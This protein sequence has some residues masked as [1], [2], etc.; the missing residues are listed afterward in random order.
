MKILMYAALVVVG[1]ILFISSSFG[2]KTWDGGAA[3]NNW[4]DANNWNPNG[5]PAITDA[6]TLLNN[7][8]VNVNVT[9]NAAS[10]TFPQGANNVTLNINSG[11]TLN[12]S[13]AVT[14]PRPASA[15]NTLAV[16]AGILNAGSIAFTNGGGGQ[17]HFLTISTGTVTVSG[18]I[19]QTGSTGSATITFTGAGL[20]QLG[21]TFLTAATCTF[22]SFAGSTVEYNGA[23]AQTIGDFP[24][25]NLKTS[26]GGT[27]TVVT[28]TSLTGVLTVNAG[29]VLD[30]N[31]VGLGTPTSVVLQGG[32]TTGSS[33]TGTT[34]TLTL[35]GNVSVNDATTGNDG[36]DISCL[37]ALGAT[38]IF[39]VA[40]D[41][42]TAADLTISGVISGAGFG[43]TKTGLGTMA[44]TTANTYTG[45]VTISAGI[46]SA[47]T[48]NN[49]GTSSSL[50][51]GAIAPTIT[52][53]AAG[54]LQYNGSGGHTTNR[55]I[56]LSGSGATIDASGSGSAVTFSGAVTGGGLGLVLTGTGLGAYSGIIGNGS[57]SLTKNGVG[58]WT[59]T[60][61]NTF[62][63]ATSINAG[64][65]SINTIQSFSGGSSSLGNPAGGAIT[66]DATGILKYTGSG[67]SSDRTFT[68]IGNGA[69]I[70]MS[71]S[72]TLT[73]SGN[74]T[75]ATNG[76][77][78]T[79]TGT[80]VYSGVIGSGAG[81]LTKNGVGTWTLS[82][83]NTYTGATAVNAGTLK[84]GIAT[85]G[86]NGAFGNLSAVT[87]AN[88]A[89]A[90]LDLSGFN[91]TIGSLSGGGA[92]GG[93]VTLGAATFTTGGDNSTTSYSGIISG[94]GAVTKSGTGAWTVS[95]LNTYTGATTVNAGTLKAGIA[96]TGAN[97]AF[98]NLSAVT[99]ANVAT[100]ILDLSG[101]NNTIGSLNGGGATGGNVTLGAATLTTGGDNSTT[102]YSGI[103]SGTGAVTKSGTGAWTVSGLNTYTGATTVN[104]GTL[105]AG[106]A[107]TGA[108]GAFGNLS[109]VTM[110]NVATAILDLS[111]FNNTIG[112]LSGGGATGGN[113]T[114]GAATLTTGGDN[115]AT[116]YSGIISGTGAVTK[117]GTGAWT[118]SGSNSYS[119]LTTVSAGTLKLGATGGA[120]NT[121]LG[122]TAAG[123]S[124]STGAALDL[125]GFTL[126]NTTTFE[127][128]TLNGAGLTASPAGALTNTGGAASYSGNI[129]LGSAST[130]TATASGSLTAS[131]TVGTGAFALTLD[132]AG[133]GT[134]SG[135][136]STPT[137]LIKNGTGTWSLSGLNTYSGTTTVNA[138]TL[139]AGV[140]TTGAN[141]AF[142]NLS[143]VTMAN[144]ATAILDLSGFNNTIGSLSGGG[145]T[146]GNVALGA[147]TLTTGGD[148]STTSYSGI[149]SGTGAVTK[150]GAGAWTLSGTNT[151]T[152]GANLSAGT[153][154]INNTQALGTAAGTF[155]ITGGN[156]DNTSA[157][158]I[159]TVSYPLALNG[160]FTY[161][162]SVPRTLNLGSGAV[163]M[164][165]N[166]Q[167]TVNAGSLV[168]LGVINQSTLNLTK[169]GAGSFAFGSQT[170]TLNNLTINASGG[171]F[172]GSSGTTNIFGDW[173]N[174]ASATA[175]SP[176]ISGF[177]V[178][179]F[180]ST[181]AAQSIGG[182]FGTT[183][184]D[185]T[186]TNT[187]ATGLSLGKDV[188]V[189]H[190]LSLSSASNGKI[191]LG[192]NNLI[193]PSGA[194]AIST[195]LS[196]KY[197][198][199]NGSGT[200][201]ERVVNNATNV[202]FPIG[203]STSYL[204]VSVQL[205]AG[206]TA[207]D[208]KARVASVV[209]SNFDANDN[210]T[211]TPLTNNV[212]NAV[213]S[214]K[215]NVAGGSVATVTTQWNGTDEA[216]DFTRSSCNVAHFE[217]GSWNYAANS[218]AGGGNPYT[219]TRSG[220]T[221]FSPFAVLAQFIL[222]APQTTTFCAG[223]NITVN[224]FG[225]GGSWSGANVFSI[226]LSNASGVFSGNT[227]TPTLTS[228]ASSGSITSTLPSG[229]ATGS[230]Y[231]VRVN[232]TVPAVTGIQSTT[233]TINALP[234]LS[235]PNS[236][237]GGGTV[238]FT[239]TAGG[240]G[241]WS[242]N[243]GGSIISGTGVFTPSTAGCFTAT[244][245]PFSVCPTSKDFLVYP[246]EPSIAAPT[247]TCNTA[248]SIP[249][250]AAVSGFTV[251][252]NIDGTGFTSTPTAPSSP[253][254]HTFIARYVNTSICGDTPALTASTNTACDASNTVSALIYPAT[255]PAPTATNTCGAAL[256][257]SNSPSAVGGFT[258][259]YSFDGGTNWS[260]TNASPTIPGC[261]T[262]QM[263]WLNNSICGGTA[264]NTP[265]CV[266]ASG[267]AIVYPSTPPSPILSSTSTCGSAITVTNSPA[268]APGFTLQ[269]S[270]DGG[271]SWSTT[272]SSGTT[273]GC[274][275][276]S[277]RWINISA[278]GA[279]AA[280]TP[281]CT[282]TSATGIVYPAT[283]PAPTA[284]N[285]C[286]TALSINNTPPPATGFTLEY[287]FDGGTSWTTTNASSTTPGCYDMQMRWLN[288]SICGVTAANTPNC[289]SASGNALVYP[290]TPP[291]PTA[292]N[293]CGTALTITNSPSAATGFTLEY[294][295]DGGSSWST[296]N[297][298]LTTPGCYTMQMRWLN[299][300]DCG[301]TAANTPNCVSASGNAI[302][303]PATPPAPILS[304]TS[305]CGSAITVTNS[306]SA[307]PGFTLQ[308]SF[309]GG[310][311]WG[312]T[313]SSGTTPGCYTVSMR[314]INIS[315]CGA[316]AANTPNCT[317]TSATGIVY[318]ATPPAPTAT[319][320]CETGL[321]INNTPPPATG[322]TLEYSF[323][324]GTSWTTTNASPTT[325]GCYDM[326]MRWLNDSACGGTAANT[327]SCTSASGNAIV[328]PSTPSAPTADNTCAS[329]LSIN[330][331]PSAVTGFTL[332]YSFDGGSSWSSTNTSPTTPGCYTMQMR[333]LNDS[334]C[335]GTAANTPNCASASGNAVIY[336]TA[337]GI[338][339]PDNSC[340]SMFTLPTVSA[341]TGFTVKY[342]LDGGAYASSPS[343]TTPGCHTIAAEYFL[344]SDCGSTTT[345]T[346]GPG[347]CGASN[348]ES[349]VIFPAAPTITAL[350]NTC[351]AQL[352][353]ISV[354]ADL[355]A[356]GFTAEYSVTAPDATT[357][358]YVDLTT[359]NAFLSNIPGCWTI[360]ARYKLTSDCGDTPANSVSA[361]P[362][363]QESTIHAVVFPP[364]P[365]APTVNTGCAADISVTPPSPVSGFN[366]EYSF[367]NGSTWGANTPPT[368]ENC[369]YLIRTRYVLA[370][371]CGSTLAGSASPVSGCDMSP[372]TTRVVDVT[373]P[374]L[375]NPVMG[376]S[377]LNQSGLDL[378]D[379]VFNPASL[380]ASVK[381]KYID[382]CTSNLTVTL[383]STTP[384]VDNSNCGWSY[385]YE[386]EIADDCGNSTLCTVN[387][388]GG[389]VSA[390]TLIN[391]LMD[392]A[393]LT[394]SIQNMC[395]GAYNPT[396]LIALVK[397]KYTDNCTANADLQVLIFD[398]TPG[399]GNTD[400]NWSYT[401]HFSISDNCFNGEFCDI[402]VTGG[403]TG[404]PTLSGS[405]ATAT[406]EGCTAGDA[407]AAATTIAALETLT[408]GIAA[409]NC[410]AHESLVVSHTDSPSGSCPVVV[411]RTYYVT[412]L[413]GNT[414]LGKVQIINV[415]D[416]TPPTIT[417]TLTP[418]TVE[419]C[420][421]ADAPAPATTVA[422][423]E[424][425]AG[426]VV[427]ADN[428]T[429][430]ASLSVSHTDSPLGT[431]P[432]VITRTY[433]VTDA[434]GNTSL[435]KVQV[436]NVEDT[437]APD[438]STQAS[439][440][441]SECQGS[442]PDANT[443]Y[444]AWL[445]SH[446]GAV[447]SDLCSGEVEWSDNSGTAVWSANACVR[448]ISITFTASDACGNSSNTTA[449][450]TIH[451]TTGP[452][453]STPAAASSSEC[454]GTNPD[455][456]TD[457]ISWLA[458][459]GGAVAS[460][461][462]SNA[463]NWT[464]N[465]GTAV[466]STNAC[467][468]T[469]S[470]TFT[471]S[472]TC[473]NS[474]NTTAV[475]TIH[476]TTGP[477]ISTPAAASSS[478]CQGTDPDANTDYIAWLA[479]HGGAV[480][481]DL[482]SNE[483]NWSDNT[484]TAAWSTNA[485]VRTISITFTA[486]DTCGN[487][488]NT[489]AVFTIHDTTPPDITTSAAPANSECQGANP[490]AN[491]D[492]IAWLA[493][494]GGAAASDLCSNEVSWT[495]NTGTAAWSTNACVRTI[496]ITFTAS[497][498][499]G[500]SS[501]TTAIF[502]IHDTTPPDITTS[503]APENS[504][505]QGANPD[506]NTDYIAWLA[507]HGGAAASDLCSNEVN[508]SDNRGTAV[509][510][511]N[512]CVRT[513][514]ITFTASDTCGNSSNTTAV[515]TIHDTTGPDISTPATASNS[516]CQGG[517]PDA[518]TDY[519]AWLASHGG[520]VASDACS[521][522]I[523]WS[524]NT[525]TAVWSTNAC[526]RTISI[527]FTAS[528]TCGNSSN[529]T[530]VFTIHDTTGPDISTPAA[531]LSSECQGTDPDANTDYIAWLASHGGAVASDLCSNAVN[532]SDNT[533][534]AVWSTNACVRTIS[535]T[536]TASDTCGNSSNTTA[537]FT[538]HDTTPP[539]ITTSAAPANS[540]C[541]GANPDANTDYIAWLASHGE[542]AASDLCSNAVNWSDNT[543]TAVWST[544]ACVRTISITFTAS[545]TCGNSSNTTAVFTIHD[546]TGPDI[547]TPAAA[548]SSECQGTNPDAN[549][550]YISWLASHGGAVASDLCSNAVN[551]TNNTGTAVWSTNAC[552]RTISI[553]FTASDTC[554]NSSNTTAVFT[555]HD[556]T[557]PDI[558][559]PAAA[560]SSEC[561]GTDPDANT[562]YIA[563]L[564]SHG[565]AV[566]SDLCSNEV[567][568]SD[569]TGTAAWSTNA[570]VRTISITFTASDTCGNSSNTTAVFTIHDTTPP[571]IT[572]S[573]APANSEC[574]GANPDA[575]TD[576]ISWLASH[577]G[578][579]ASDLCSNAVNWSDNT[580]TAVWSTNACVRTISVTFT[581][582][583]TC[584]NSSNTTAVFTIHDTTP[585]DITTSAAAANSECQGANP[586]ANTD[587]IAWLASH[588][589]AAASDL[590]SNAVN[591]SDNT[592]TAVW[593]TNACVRT[594]SITFTASDTC[595]NSS[596]T[597]AVFTI[598]DTTGPD[599][600]TPA[601]ASNSECQGGD[602]DANTDYIAWLASHGGAVASDAC[603]NEINWSDNTGTAVWSTNACVRTI[604]ITFTASDTCGNSSNTTAVFTI[605]DTTGPD[606]STPAAAS[607]SECQGTDPDAN[608]DYISWLASHGGATASDLCS[609]EV[610][611][612]DNTGTAVWSTN[613]CVRTISITFTASDTCGNSS[614]TTAVFTIHDTTPPDITTS[615]APANSECQ[616]A[617]PDANTD[618]ISWLASHGG[619]AASD[620]CSNAVNWSDNTGTAVWSTNA[621]VRTISVTFTASDTCG[622][623]SNTTAV[624]TIHD[625][626][627]PDIT[628]SAA[629]A[630]SECQGANPDA[631]TDYIAWL[632][633]HGE[634]A[635]SDLCS[636]AVNWSDNT[637]TAVWSTNACVRTISIT[638]TA[639]DTCGNSS[640]TTAVFTIHDTTGP[641]ISTPAAA[642][643]SECQ[644]TNPDANTDYISWLASHGGAVASDLCSNAV[645]WTNNTGTAV[646]STN[647]CVRT[648]SITFTA[649]D[650]CGNSS[651]TTAVFT[652][653]DTTGPDI[654]TPA[655][656]SS[657]E[658]QGTDPDANTDY[659]AWLASH[660][661][662]VASD[663][664]SN[665][666]NWS[667][668]TGTAAWSTN[669]CVRTISI[670][671]T[672]SDT[673]G[674]S[675]NT[676]A[677]FTIH[678][679]TPPDI[680]TSA[681][682]ANS[683]CQGANP[684]ANTDYISW[685]ASHG[686][687]A[688]S[689]LCSNA[690]NW[691]DNTGTAVWS[692]NA[693]VRTISV[694]FTAS[695]TCGNSSNTTAVFTIHDTTPPD[696]TTSAA[697][698]NSECQG[699]NPDANTDYIAW[700]A[701]HGEAAASD[702]C[703]NAVNWSD[704]TGTAVWSTNACVRTISITFTASDTCGN[705]SNTTAVFTIHDTTG[706]DI[707]TPATASNS[708]C[709]GG[710]PDANTDYIA[711]L[712]SHGGAVASDACSNEINWS[713]NTGTAVWSTNACVRTI[714]ITF[715]ASDTCGNSS[716]T[717]AVFTIHDTTGPDI[718]TPA[719]AAMSE[720]QGAN[721]DANTEYIAWL[722]SH[723]GAA[724]SDLCSN[725]VNWT[726]NTG[727]AVWSTNACVRT[728]SITFTASDTCGNA[729]NT[730][731]IFTIHDTT[732]PDITTPAA[733]ANSECQGANP[734][735]NTDY[736]AW[737][738]SHGG[739][740]ASDLCSNEVNWSDNTGTA[741][742]STNACVRTIS[743]TFTAADTCGNSSN[744]TAVFT[745][746]DTTGPDIST[747]AAAA[748]SECQGTDPNANTDY[749]AWLA[750]HG[751]AAASDL[752]SNE[753]N[754]TENTGTAVWSTNACVRT[755]SITFTA[756]DT[757]GNSSNT[758]AV[759]TIHDT[760]GPDIST[761][762]A[763]ANSEC[764][765]TDPNA[766][767]DYIAWLASH[768]GAAASDLC[769]NEVNWSDNTGTAAWSTNAC[770]R[771]IS[772]TFTA[773]DTCGNSSN[774]IAVFTIHDTTGPDITTPAAA[775]NSE[776]QGADPNANTDYILWLASHGGAAASDLCSNAVNWTDNTGT[777]V[778]STNACVR[779]ISITFTASDT[780][781]NSSNTTA[782][783]TIHDT[784]A[785]D[786]T[787]EASNQT[788]ECDGAGNTTALTNWLS[789][790]GGAVANDACS[791]VTWS[792]DFTALSD[793]CGATGT[794]T[795]HFT[796]TDGCGNAST[797]TATFTIEDI[798]PPTLTCPADVTIDCSAS[799]L[800]GVA[801]SA[802]F[803]EDFD[804]IA[805]PTDGGP[806][807]YS[808]PA[809]WL[810]VNV[811]NN[812]PA[813]NPSVSWIHEAW[814]RREDFPLNNLD[815][816][817]FATSYYDPPGTA[818][819]W[820]WTPPIPMGENGLLTWNAKSY[821]D[822][823]PEAYSVRVMV[824]PNVPTGTTGFIG[825][826][827]LQSFQ[828]FGTNAENP[829]WT[830]R[831]VDL[832]L[833]AGKTIRIAFRDFS[834]DQFSILIDDVVVTSD[835]GAGVG[836]A[837]AV[838]ACDTEPTVTYAD[839]TMSGNCASNY[840]I[841]RTWT[842][843]DACGNST[844]CMQTIVVHDITPPLMDTEA[845]DQT[846][847]CDGAGNN[848]ALTNWLS[849][850]GGAMASD[851][852]S[853]VTWSNDFTTLSDGCG[854][855]GTTTVHFTATDGCGNASTTTATFTIQ[856]TTPPAIVPG[857]T[858]M[859]V[860]CD[861]AGNT[862]ALFSW[863]SSHGGAMA[864]DACSNVTWSDDYSGLSDDCGMT[865]SA[866]VHFTAT[867]A[868][869]NASTTT[870]TF[871]IHDTMAPA[872]VPGA[873]N[874]TV[875][876]DGAG[877]ITSLTTWLSTNG[878][879]VA[880]ETCSIA[881]W[882]NDFTGLSDGCG[883][884]GSAT[885]HFTATD[886]CGN[887][888]TTTATFTIHDTMAPAIVPGATNLTVECD[889]AGNTSQLT[890]WLS[891]HGGA[892]AH[893]TCSIATWS[894]DF[895]GLSDGCGE[896]GTATVHFTATDQCGNASTTTATFTI[897]D[898][899]PPVLTSCPPN[900]TIDCPSV[901]SFGTPM[902]NNACDASPVVSIVSTITTPSETC[903]QA[904]S[905]TRTWVATD[906][907]GN[908]SNTCSQV[909]TVIDDT[910]PV[911]ENC[912]TSPAVD[913]ISNGGFETTDL[914]GWTVLA[915]NNVGSGCTQGYATYVGTFVGCP[916]AN[917]T[918]GSQN[919]TPPV[920]LWG[921]ATAFDADAPLT[922]ELRQTVSLPGTITL[923]ALGFSDQY[924]VNQLNF[925]PTCTGTKLLDVNILDA[926]GTTV[927]ANV[928]NRT[929]P[930]GANY[931]QSW[932]A[933]TLDITTALQPYAGQNVMLSF[934][935][936]VP[937]A[938]AGP[939][940]YALDNVSLLVS[941]GAVLSLG[942]NPTLPD[943]AKAI[944][945][946][947][948]VSDACGAVTESATGT[949]PTQSNC[950]Y[951]QTWTVVAQDGCG[952]SSSCQISYIWRIDVTPPVV[953]CPS[954]GLYLGVNPTD[955]DSD[956]IPDG[957]AT[958]VNWSDGCSASGGTTQD[959]TDIE[960]QLTGCDRS[961]TRQFSATDPCGNTGTC[962]VTYTWKV[963]TAPPVITCP[964]SITHDNDPGTCGAVVTYTTPT[965]L[966][967]CSGSCP[968]SLPGYVYLG[969]LSGHEY[970]V[971]TIVSTFA[972][973]KLN[974]YLLGGHLATV[975]SA[976]EESFITTATSLPAWIGL[977][978][979]AT[980]GTFQWITGEPFSYTDWAVDQP[981]NSTEGED[982]VQL[983]FSGGW[984]DDS[985]NDHLN[986]IVEFDCDGPV[987]ISG[988]PSG[989]T[990]PGGV[991]ENTFITV[992]GAGNTATCSFTVT[993]NDVEDPSFTTCPATANISCTDSQLP[994]FTGQ[995][996]ATDNCSM[997]SITY[998]DGAST[999]GVPACGGNYSFIRTWTATDVTG[1000]SASCMQIINVTDTQGPTF[1001][1002][1003]PPTA[1004]IS[1005]T[1006][1007]QLPANT[1008]LATATD[1009]CSN[1010]TMTYNDGVST[1011]G[1012]PTCAGNYS[1013]TRT[1014][1015]ATDDCGNSTT[1016]TQSISVTDT[1017]PPV[1018]NTPAGDQMAECD[1019]AGNSADITAWL[1020]AH[1021]GAAATDG[1022]SG[1023]TWT[1024]DFTGVSD[1025]CGSTGSAI[1026][1027][1028]TATDGC[1029]NASTTTATFTI[1030]DTTAP[1031]ITQEAS[1032]SGAE[1033][1034]G[1035]GNTAALTAW[1036]SSQGGASASDIC[1037]GVTWSNDFTTLSDGCGSTGSATVHFTATDACGNASTTTAT[1038]T[1039][1040]DTTAPSITVGA[1041][1042]SGAECD[1043]A[1044]NTAALTAWLSSQGGASASD[1045][1046]SGVTWTN[1047]FT[1048][1049]SDGCGST[1050]T[1051]M[1052]HFTA[1053]DG[1054]GNASTTT[1055]TFTIVDTTAPGITVAAGNQTVECDGAGNTSDLSAWLSS[1056]GGADAT[1057]ICSGVT[1058]TNDFTSLS[1059][1060]CGSTGTATVHFTATDG[1061]GNASTT[1062][1063]TFT[1064]A[1065]TTAPTFS[1066]AASNQTVQCDGAGNASDL[1067][1068]WLSGNGGA[1069]AIDACSG[1070]TWSNN[1071]TSLSD[1072]CGASGTAI[1073]TFAAT[1074]GCGNTG[1075]TTA[1076]F[1077]IIDTTVPMINS[1078][1079]GDVTK[1080]CQDDLSVAGTGNAAATDN[1081]D[1082]SPVITHT[1083]VS[1084][1085]GGD[1086]ANCS[1087][1088]N[1089]T[1090][1091]R[1092]FKATDAC[1093]NM[1094][1095]CTQVITVHDVTG[1096]VVTTGT[1097]NACYE[1098][1099]A[1100]AE[1101]AAIAATTAVDNCA[1102]SVTKTADISQTVDASCDSLITVTV[1103]DIC[1104]NTSQTTYLT[1105]IGCQT[1106]RLKVFLEGPYNTVNDNMNTTINNN[1107]LLPGQ[1108]CTLPFITDT[1109]HGQPY[1110]TPPYNYNGNT[1111]M[1112]YGDFSGDT[1113]YPPDVVDWILVSVRR[1114]SLN[1115][1116]DSTI[1117]TCAGWLHK[1118]GTVTFPDNCPGPV[1119]DITKD[1120]YIMVQ[1121]RN[1122]LGILSPSFVDIDCSGAFLSWD[1123]T[1124]QDSYK[1125]PFRVGEKFMDGIWAMLAANGD[1126]VSSIKVISS[1127]D[1128]TIW[1129]QQQSSSGYKKADH[1130]LN[1131]SVNSAD[1132]TLWKLN[1133]NKTTG[1134]IFY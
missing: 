940:W 1125:P 781:G 834:E 705:S 1025:G 718:T 903:A 775:A 548:S 1113:P 656:A 1040:V 856:D 184:Y 559:T 752:C 157:G 59:L 143:A 566:A 312:T 128:L 986:Y 1041:S 437:T 505:C 743:I 853:N 872:I 373:A 871:T 715:T 574:Q 667:D 179:S 567:N 528:D 233:L 295:F 414:S 503:A 803:Q 424:A 584:G 617:N 57:G 958:S 639:S 594:I 564:A 663:L 1076:T 367:N 1099:V 20:L 535:I 755:I 687:A 1133:Q 79:G 593:S 490:D 959:F 819:D 793:G 195:P 504:E 825:N 335:G 816:V 750:S 269:Y 684:D 186:N 635:A 1021:A 340:A 531:A 247:N 32:A 4:G 562:D 766:N 681:A 1098:S 955:T 508:W 404:L 314:W 360:N 608:T 228:T 837:T 338:T 859:T 185:L 691:S 1065:D 654:S 507:S 1036:L 46:L 162:G 682:P 296:T 221:A 455:A 379:G 439:A 168:I 720:C 483:V 209:S 1001:T 987:L 854:Q 538:I 619:A 127:A 544:N 902:A 956:L 650:T 1038:F 131:G 839:V 673:C 1011:P 808:F 506:A 597:T 1000:N 250:V 678:D 275:T 1080:N 679:T 169:A 48:L 1048:T 343:T 282:S 646:W 1067:A 475:F 86:A 434:C 451:D 193:L 1057:D 236:C 344:T 664:C 294:S 634:A 52:I 933:R 998:V 603:S 773:S 452:D 547:S 533:G 299:D 154:N 291:A 1110:N 1018:I 751:G 674:N 251:Q 77:V 563:W 700:L 197:I 355:T 117:S 431:C 198:V 1032:N 331:S 512:A 225:F 1082:A 258:L 1130:D 271:G 203:T 514:S 921:V 155:T 1129:S 323:D 666:V 978:D 722:D 123:T 901:P 1126:Q 36:A 1059:D 149:I 1108:D 104:A 911:F 769:S 174:N 1131:I 237:I 56:T 789:T 913:L 359:A 530:A 413:C 882:S 877:N 580:G 462:C 1073:V 526:V 907:C 460:D 1034:D 94:T 406:V 536:F 601:T 937:E 695:D 74:L 318:P 387:V 1028:F 1072:G 325:P 245:N 192:N 98:G 396:P 534:T 1014:W 113:V 170:I 878:G 420:T 799:T 150:I 652:I 422:E 445:V 368:A 109:A 259:Q 1121:H 287:S 283:P 988:L 642:S 620:L 419:G 1054:C 263:R 747:P 304:S 888:S 467:V 386:F 801:G 239:Q 884:T 765:G 865:G 545:D 560:S 1022:C 350:S 103:I 5:V 723:G 199:T 702:L 292:T 153:L 66:I 518:N 385:D 64:T 114:L 1128:R 908:T 479:S 649:S 358:G 402:T 836:T 883:M 378:C 785:P 194:T 473:G 182:S 848:T 1051:A 1058:W 779:T 146:G 102:S 279:T 187:N 711:W 73:L 1084:T 659:I 631:N 784:T 495:D 780:C 1079:P 354:V 476:D 337:P 139:K 640:N 134:M 38:R 196:S 290:A 734:D 260:S 219:Q 668:N 1071:F 432:I 1052:V 374:T 14:I 415:N 218:A 320:T 817:A 327:P 286:G 305:T 1106:V 351:N 492:Y 782:V 1:N 1094:S 125:A 24:Y 1061:C 675:S 330:N 685:L 539:D 841:H 464:N 112:S 515:F 1097:I 1016:C 144:V 549:T 1063:A 111:G 272:N 9:G 480:A 313:N 792:N 465:T 68:L 285:T 1042:N 240:P 891:S 1049:L 912:V 276:V 352:A 767:T 653:H 417:G 176:S 761:P 118:V 972:E 927:L 774:T 543:G 556:T 1019:G 189:N 499:C 660:G 920:G 1031:D 124:V 814:D 365:P 135:I 991:T 438:I 570:C 1109:P 771:T 644:G 612:S 501:N 577:G 262:M 861:G 23:G 83:L 255:P 42:T 463:V 890:T 776:C 336:P 234:V 527:T 609:N 1029:G 16:G 133:T 954:T 477:D 710:D 595:G 976:G 78:L 823:F 126:A 756:S 914:T 141:G 449:V 778:W 1023:V 1024:N 719:A 554:G 366:T 586:D 140:A 760:T 394:P 583:D 671:F 391:P 787:T 494:H 1092:T 116:S 244:Y 364:A 145:V 470:I 332:E 397:S 742:W 980:E 17:R 706:P 517:D 427:A 542:A 1044:G 1132:E 40:D 1117:W 71:G 889:G 692:T 369:G 855:T 383:F 158:N 895:S 709:Q 223:D 246:A 919:Y 925:C 398:T 981:D 532:W 284:T 1043:G 47:N 178:V 388:S 441:N 809:G 487:S 180:N 88:V 147:A 159:T 618:Y 148:N 876:C 1046:C 326:Q 120:T 975:T 458:S 764:Q 130:I 689:D 454:Q 472:D 208:I 1020:T 440:A 37:L 730:T 867:D 828:V 794:A 909:I 724:A 524:D 994:A 806:G 390:P 694:T 847:E 728:I 206:S 657:S 893:E 370:S 204:P 220:I 840:T 851:A 629:P 979:E 311:S 995:A 7:T 795:V 242:V 1105:R 744:T 105:K 401:Y 488:S 969:N 1116:P 444:I 377:A 436:I 122:T 31:T 1010:A 166:R 846:V 319:N 708:E 466:W 701:S 938:V 813:A 1120:Y 1069:T 690:V 33:I 426:G 820:M 213:W 645:N 741:V 1087:Y 191:T 121:P 29:S 699:A 588:G 363:C 96:T 915:D 256:T 934:R 1101:S 106:I 607:S 44:L 227:L 448:T 457:Y 628:T 231:R 523:N 624:F 1027:H 942:C 201:Q 712:A 1078:C 302:V 670:T 108:N 1127:P 551:W 740:A 739:A 516:E 393:S 906:A 381:A 489:T 860:E 202:V 1134:V 875:E 731:A 842:S 1062:T 638:F 447:A 558:S 243:G 408:G 881:T 469:I 461:L 1033:C 772:I 254:C 341:V 19:T 997:T 280:N 1030:V 581:A 175:Y 85:T 267:N 248:L 790:N 625:T 643:S 301:G 845:S 738:A 575:N 944:A 429:A 270:F 356:S 746:H 165:A 510:S 1118:D 43:V 519:I 735:A 894:D 265:N 181:S 677:V 578:A 1075:Y 93:N 1091:T 1093:N 630:N 177:G 212:V 786:I 90:I 852:C 214:L 672:A 264:A 966:E 95:G 726:D 49:S 703:S 627:P 804:G 353:N 974:A 985:G 1104:G 207:D 737:L 947:G 924:F 309:D 446:G 683:E 931:C 1103:T 826:M 328:Y 69:T 183:F 880:H 641:D 395:D 957:V 399:V 35:G 832:S 896:T 481:S 729:S 456:N 788:V 1003:C 173:T 13:G 1045:L 300:S 92:T 172:F 540:E 946:I 471:A 870:A 964:S 84:A 783:F 967:E 647:A 500:N 442:D 27:K 1006:D 26:G 598:H 950:D 748:N 1095:T 757:C 838:D 553:T 459:H 680:T 224:Y 1088:Y 885:V 274:Y 1102:T 161:L 375:V 81:N 829:T 384:G 277:M 329:A 661:G 565:G 2:Q 1089:Y 443:D 604:S 1066:P 965:V 324:G 849:T 119:G 39:N 303:Y 306:P 89:T 297:A 60:N 132:G 546:T 61:A 1081:C 633:S 1123:F 658:C 160:D 142:G 34:G 1037:S 1111:G 110:A 321:V 611:W 486:S 163:T 960:S 732:P 899:T 58:T 423:L 768:G 999:P 493:S 753:V 821:S 70:D 688:A 333:W 226:E 1122:H 1119:I 810:R 349:V 478:E 623:S 129:T 322:F 996:A 171:T 235:V 273:P 552:V 101:F 12:V 970:F 409:D 831:S 361:D 289:V 850:H 868:C 167:I 561:Q 51:T 827:I 253:G 345:L 541:Q 824:D 407:P 762:A 229:L 362:V 763:A 10:I 1060:L 137:S 815:S 928:Y 655:A 1005:C 857:A 400:C 3:T 416:T 951:T 62:T 614:N 613:A 1112:Q 879:A 993:V 288:N 811:D 897:H 15:S 926:T 932:T 918:C 961:V 293:T 714:S 91:N 28:G 53:A 591:W 1053:T 862:T 1124:I 511:T 637:G 80:G 572:T 100:A 509:W 1083:D 844:A 1064:I 190:T 30:V 1086:P 138:G 521:N 11:I 97:G 550:D 863:L 418:T 929:F 589:E 376:C 1050:G 585:P 936:T 983:N 1013:F 529:T 935:I 900:I 736:I 962:Q 392:C 665:E 1039:I 923:A 433:Y 910:P 252:Y 485:C 205:T 977:T 579:A 802:N 18:N 605:H 990:F 555:I 869:G 50:G 347:S 858:N 156:I 412:D 200:L 450:F 6:V 749:I 241:N 1026:V 963:D 1047:D 1017:T 1015:T 403:D 238:T 721:P 952:N 576:Y 973:A 818:D 348:T 796:A 812:T 797:T 371:T 800:P 1100:L 1068:A 651:N 1070:V 491:T 1085:Q 525:G 892:T 943:A 696:I 339:A 725:A 278:C 357:T 569:N 874:M 596:N 520:A 568:W 430:H 268:A 298:S 522:E 948:P 87:M 833:F 777:A 342:S 261:Y 805:G 807:T 382:N 152:G 310:S 887:A 76:L 717:I 496:S 636:N 72:G 686:G 188:T 428:C 704:N 537:V 745:I 632:A 939:G 136:I 602:P 916:F 873:T 211:G 886:Q 866:T 587:Y 107:T 830:P 410:T 216:S 754:W 55:P 115:S 770:V 316:T 1090:I 599:I 1004:N 905:M 468:R 425:L 482:C 21:G 582:S 1055:A 1008:G 626:T 557:G 573:A 716:N 435:G 713:D 864:S 8:T 380:I 1002:F 922:R 669:A 54:T 758:T 945:D 968:I 346:P 215:E 1077:T 1009:A 759:F 917:F 791:T 210:P 317:S 698:A 984:N 257:I 22:T 898:T 727:T 1012:A 498:T 592:G 41:G 266:S 334:D 1035:A 616:G 1074:D 707:S 676:T 82:G 513:I 1056:N 372:A 65:L 484:G 904:Y 835:G 315:A 232:S 693:C 1107:H 949:I 992:D 164:N 222:A 648:I 982:Y 989:S 230:V 610:S 421:A 971:S 63:G 621:C 930:R 99:M 474:S 822:N 615:A 497:D 389:D 622:N 733:A 1115:N 590:C 662:A 411:T 67:N 249:S 1114:T 600:S 405:I 843:T 25:V 307:A 571:D 697:A 1007:S 308:Y 217:S 798:T 75:N 953:E 941:T 45:A 281:N 1096:P 502:T 606:I 151:F 453:I